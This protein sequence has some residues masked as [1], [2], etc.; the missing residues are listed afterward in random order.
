[1][2]VRAGDVSELRRAIED[3]RI[4]G[5]QAFEWKDGGSGQDWLVWCWRL[6]VAG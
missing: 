2:L 3:H 5:Q 1:M 4:D 6:T